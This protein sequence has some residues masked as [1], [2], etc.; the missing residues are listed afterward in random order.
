PSKPQP[1]APPPPPPAP[2]FPLAGDA[3]FLTSTTYRYQTAIAAKP[4]MA[5]SFLKELRRRSRASFRTET[6]TDSS[7]EESHGTA[8]TTGSIT[9]PSLSQTS[10]SASNFPFKDSATTPPN[11]AVRPLPQPVPNSNSKRHSVNGMAG[12]GS[13]ASSGRIPS[14]PV[15][16][17]SPR[18]AN[19]QDGSW[20]Y[21]KVLL[22]H[23]TI[24]DPTLQ[25]LDG[26][27]TVS[28][29]D[30]GFPPT[31]WPVSQSHFKA[32]V[33]MMP[34][35]N[36]VRFDF[37]SPK[38]ANSGTSNPIHTSYLT[39]HMLPPT[40]APPL[41]LAILMAKD[42][43]GTFDAVPARIEREGNGLETAVRKFR[44]AAYLWQA[45]TAEQ[46]WRNKLG[47][48]TFHFEE[49][50]TQGTSN[51]RDR[52]CGQM[53]SEARIHIVRTDKTVAELRD[54][55]RAQQNPK[56]TDKDA[57]YGIALDALRNYFQPKAGQQLHVSVLI[58]DA[59]W[60]KA[61]KT[62]TA[63]AA[64]GGGAGDL[65]V[66]I[67]GSH[68]LQ[69]YP[70]SFEEVVPAL[71]D[72]TPTDL[73]FVGND[74][75]DAGSSWEA[76]NI[77]IGAHLHE[78][79]HALGLPHRE[80]G[81]ML[82]DYVTFNRTF[83]AREAYSTRTRSKGGLVLQNDECTWHRL[84][85]LHFRSHPCFRLPNDP[86]MN[87]D[88]SVQ[89]WPVDS[90]K[91]AI[92][93]AT[94]VA[95]LEI[96]GE[97]DDVCRSWIEFGPENGVI[98][99]QIILTD[100]DLRNRLP[101]EKRKGRVKVCIKS[102]GGGNLDIDDFRQLSSK[103]SSLK[104]GNALL[105]KTAYRS[106]KF[107]LSQ[108]EGSQP[109]EVIFTSALR[110]DR[111]LSR[112]I[113]YH[114]FAMDGME[115][116]YDDDSRQLFGKRGGKAGGDSFEMDIRRGEYISGFYIRSGFW[117]DGIQVLTS[118]GRKSPVYGN[119]HGGSAGYTICA[120]QLL[121]SFLH[122]GITC[123]FSQIPV[124]RIDAQKLDLLDLFFLRLNCMPRA[125]TISLEQRLDRPPKT[126]HY[127]TDRTTGALPCSLPLPQISLQAR[128]SSNNGASPPQRSLHTR[129]HVRARAR[130]KEN[131]PLE[132]IAPICSFD[133]SCGD[134]FSSSDK[135]QYFLATSATSRERERE[136]LQARKKL[137]RATLYLR[138]D[139]LRR[140]P[141]G[142]AENHLIPSLLP[143]EGLNPPP[144]TRQPCRNGRARLL[145]ATARS[146]APRAARTSLLLLSS[147]AGHL[148]L[149]RAL[150]MADYITELNGFCGV[151]SIFS[152]LRYCLGDPAARGNIYLALGF[153]PLGL[154]FDFMDGKVARWRGK[155]SMM[156]QEL[157]SLADLQERQVELS[158]NVPNPLQISFGVSPA[159]VAFSIGCRT[160]AD[161]VLLAF[162]VLCGLTRLARFN[163]TASVIPK[164]RSGKASYFE[165]TPIPTSLG[166]D[167]LMAYWVS[168]G[169]T[170]EAL[171]G[172]TWLA[173]S[174]LEVHP[175]VLLFVLHGFLMTSKSIHIPKP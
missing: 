113:F 93:A 87:P 108:M 80:S 29:L 12:L 111:V 69:S 4:A 18:I 30:D 144:Q 145:R 159:V 120:P 14:L 47:R 92:T 175:V 72:C 15:S 123:G 77:G 66:G 61:S 100:Q 161:H 34:G 129:N 132:H 75:N 154:F 88:D 19:V 91:V 95:Y 46:M 62:I 58:L 3:R 5:P 138:D 56:A 157:D 7:S 42:S 114:G 57:L 90:G 126:W 23:G 117:I 50:W 131:P 25:S 124:P 39:I 33:Y 147:D 52:E 105:G 9:P 31:S 85:C 27:L 143:F 16:Q 84:D 133:G 165:G 119:A 130:A 158:S 59:H 163:V 22:V 11:A 81:V 55:N 112:I 65:H 128:G 140:L 35:P 74:C 125:Q 162:F 21:Q 43:P 41:Q 102:V 103:G 139:I 170:H 8:P 127:F 49:E 171:P 82:R 63:H 168:R 40:N 89:A 78:T 1:P 156:G 10:D 13:P 76:C 118:L 17:F 122:D 150:H 94:G 86:P 172:G 44:M 149:M 97:G 169:W 164:D 146:R 174:A 151:M 104:L 67:F 121:S 24:G 36:R 64:L 98:E 53:R 148:S 110:Q 167:A 106:C 28:R 173:G 153:L 68:C 116:V 101:E 142:P 141:P 136:T 6:S 166:L 20:V 54:L 26:N 70:T 79:G 2:P 48:R 51:Y 45:F 160:A 99:R 38:L 60:D 96:F 152:S 137:W 109:Q 115:F 37:S 83:L 73:N 135:E 71:T 134:R 32:L 107:G 155:S